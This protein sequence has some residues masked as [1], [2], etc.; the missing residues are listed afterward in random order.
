M[1]LDACIYAFDISPKM[2]EFC[3]EEFKNNNDFNANKENSYEVID[4]KSLKRKYHIIL[5]LWNLLN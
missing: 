1:Y 4:I 5:K 2:I 3:N